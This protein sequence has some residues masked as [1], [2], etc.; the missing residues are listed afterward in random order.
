MLCKSLTLEKLAA[1]SLSQLKNQALRA[2]AT[3]QQDSTYLS[4][5][6]QRKTLPGYHVPKITPELNARAQHM[7]H[8]SNQRFNAATKRSIKLNNEELLR[9]IRAGRTP[10]TDFSRLMENSERIVRNNIER[11]NVRWKNI[12]TNK[13]IR[14]QDVSYGTPI[15]VSRQYDGPLY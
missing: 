2:M 6:L 5:L 14:Q 10:S 9:D 1:R 15:R 11:G 12:R 13:H 7:L 8:R 4:K 3:S